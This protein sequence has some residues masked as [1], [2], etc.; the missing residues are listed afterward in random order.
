MHEGRRDLIRLRVELQ[1]RFYSST[2]NTRHLRHEGFE[3]NEKNTAIPDKV[4][5]T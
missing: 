3:F 5:L 2:I 4:A 1:R